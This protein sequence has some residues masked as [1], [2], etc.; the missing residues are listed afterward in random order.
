M[1]NIE[2]I[3]KE[4]AINIV[5]KLLK[6]NNVKPMVKSEIL[7]ALM[8]LKVAFDVDKVISRIESKDDDCGCGKIDVWDA[9]QMVKEGY[10]N[11]QQER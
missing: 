11:M 7:L 4:D 3:N 9:V 2:L 5:S 8:D 1:N 10:T 6:D